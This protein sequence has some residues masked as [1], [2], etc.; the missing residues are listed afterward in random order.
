MTVPLCSIDGC[1]RAKHARSWCVTH[2]SRWRFTGST[3]DPVRAQ[4]LCEVD[5]CEG[6]HSCVGYC[7][8]HY[9][10][11]RKYG[12]PHQTP[13]ADRFWA[14]VTKT[15]GCW[16]WPGKPGRNGYGKV[17][18]DNKPLYAHRA[19]YELAVGPIPDGLTI[20]HLCHNRMCVN[21]THL[22]VVTRAENGRRGSLARWRKAA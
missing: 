5:G 18:R 12:T 21:P 11:F 16:Q 8:K 9:Q 2:Y 20:D 10:R 3:D 22:E 15:D 19:A 17:S 13:F 6:V 4:R 14:N 7:T 1:T